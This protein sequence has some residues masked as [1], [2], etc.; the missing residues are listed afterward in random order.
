MMIPFAIA[1]IESEGDRAVMTD[2][3]LRHR[4]LMLK[5]AW[6]YTREPSEVEDIVSDS[7]VALIQHLEDLKAM[8]AG[9]QRSYII[10]VVKH[11]AIDA[12]RKKAREQGR[13]AEIDAEQ[14]EPPVTFEHKITVQ[15]EIDMVKTVLLSLP[16]RERETLTM[17]FFERRSDREI[18]E[19]LGISENA[20]RR[21]IMRGRS[22]LK[23][24]LYEEEKT[25]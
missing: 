8:E 3:Y 4:A 12:C 6:Q 16:E 20:V 21:Y 7:C 10:T 19:A 15:A 23:A 14:L 13:S 2:I 17:K 22:H 11:K 5:I 25:E 24:A 9:G 1:A 18:A